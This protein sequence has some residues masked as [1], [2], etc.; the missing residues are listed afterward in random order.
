ME[1]FEDL[2]KAFHMSLISNAQSPIPL[3]FCSH[4]YDL[5]LR[6]RY[7]AGDDMSYQKRDAAKEH[8]D[9]LTA[10][11]AHDGDIASWAATRRP[12]CPANLSADDSL[13]RGS[14]GD[15]R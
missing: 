13:T 12:V 6:Y 7:L 10:I 8:A 2:H 5:N 11:I 4:L 1:S 14:G 3:R 9:I 15:K